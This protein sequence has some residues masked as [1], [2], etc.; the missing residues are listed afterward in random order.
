[1][2]I[3]E[4][5]LEGDEENNNKRNCVAELEMRSK[6]ILGLLMQVECRWRRTR[7]GSARGRGGRTRSQ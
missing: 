5:G 7:S 1:M 4:E 6:M 2:R 3:Q